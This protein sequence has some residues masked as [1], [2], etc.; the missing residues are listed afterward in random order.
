[1]SER[2][3]NSHRS[4]VSPEVTHELD[5]AILSFDDIQA[6]LNY[7]QAQTVLHNLVAGLDL[8]PR[9]RQGLEPEIYGLESMMD[10]LDRQVVHIAAFGMVGRGKSSLLNALLGRP[11]F[12]T[13]PTHGVT[14]DRQTADWLIKREALAGSDRSLTRVT[15]PTNSDAHIELI[16]TPGI[17]EVGGEA[18]EAL[19]RQV[20]QQA[21]LIL[22]VVAGDMTKVEYQA[23]SQLRQVSK[24]IILV[25]NK[26]DQYPDAD[27]QMIYRK[28][29]D[30]RVKELLSPNE[31]VMAAASPLVAKAVKRPD[32]RVVAQMSTG[33]PQIEDLKLKILEILDREGKSLV[34]INSMLFADDISE[35]LV[36]RKM[37]IREQSANQIIWNG[38][39]TKAVAVA[40]N[41]VAVVD[42]VT[43]A[44]I[45]V[46]MIVSL[47]RLY[48]LPMTQ[49]GAL[50]LLRKIALTMGGIS[51][52][53]LLA[54]LGLS[55]LKGLL[56]VA[57]PA[58]GGVSLAAYA[59]VAL[60]Q[61]GVA[62]VSSYGIGQVAKAYLANG[63]SWGAD[64]PKAVVTRILES[65]DERSI[66][67]R[68][69]EELR[70]KLDFNRRKL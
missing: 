43:S 9:E 51:A 48:G 62:G 20:A 28:I 39:M 8:T 3:P 37:A 22:F 29:R 63:A 31:I 16:D 60:T 65:L 15:L 26:I 64:G 6:E 59:S 19:A 49:Q 45:D 58:T 57:A 53:E 42:L 52:S 33:K 35:R 41:P 38:V 14:R 30:E 66:L 67:S 36:Q 61:A 56:G 10:K 47:S 70:A 44:V 40:L 21:D 7:R 54:N 11:I 2:T 18:R 13:G 46:A 25:F 68:I 34:A 17:D 24:P 55:S 4:S 69:K 32:G 50:A 23:L 27:R 1:M 12:E 5:E